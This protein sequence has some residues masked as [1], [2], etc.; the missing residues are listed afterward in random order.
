MAR[1]PRPD[2]LYTLRVPTDVRISPDGSRVAYVVKESNAGK[3]D[4]RQSLWVAPFDGS[5]PARRL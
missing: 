3:D 1:A 4:Y 2:D 5:A